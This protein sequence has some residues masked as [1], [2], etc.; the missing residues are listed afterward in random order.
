MTEIT[1]DTTNPTLEASDG[2][3]ELR[4]GTGATTIQAR[5]P[6]NLIQSDKANPGLRFNDDADTGIYSQANGE[7]G[8]T[9]DGENIL[10]CDGAATTSNVNYLKVQ[11]ADLGQAP[12]LT[13]DGI[14]ANA[15]LNL[16]GKGT[17]QVYVNGVVPADA[18]DVIIENGFVNTTDSTISF[19]DGTRTFTIAPAVT[20]FDF[21]AGGTKYTK[22]ASEDVVITDQ[23]GIHAIYYNGDTLTAEYAPTEADFDNLIIPV[24]AF[25]AAIYWDA[26]NNKSLIVA[27]E[28]HGRSMDSRTH[29][30]LHRTVGT[31]FEQGLALAD[32]AAD[33]TGANDTH[34]Q[35]GYASGVIW[36]EDIKISID[37]QA[38]GGTIPL[39]YRSGETDWR[40][41]DSTFTVLTTG[42]GRAAVNTNAGSPTFWAQTEVTNGN[43]VLTHYF[44]TGD[45][46]NPV[47]GV[48]GQNEYTTVANARAGAL[49]E[50]S[51]IAYGQLAA[52]TP[53]FKAIATVINQ[54]S[55]T[56][57][58]TPKTRVRTTDDGSD[59]LDW[60]EDTTLSSGGAAATN[61]NDLAGIQG[62]A[63]N[64]YQHLTTAQ[65]ALVTGALQDITS[66]PVGDLSDVTVTSLAAG[67]VLVS[68][69]SPAT[70]QNATLAEAG[71]A[72]ASHTH[73]AT[74]IDAGASTDGQV[75]TSDGAGNAAWEDAGGGGGFDWF[76][77]DG[78]SSTPE[79][80]PTSYAAGTGYQP[81]ALGSGCV[82]N[83]GSDNQGFVFGQNVNLT[84]FRA[85]AF[86][87]NLNV[88]GGQNLAYHMDRSSSSSMS[89][90]NNIVLSSAGW[91]V[92]T[93]TGTNN[94][95]IGGNVD[96]V[97]ASRDFNVIIGTDQPW[98]A[99]STVENCVGLGRMCSFHTWGEFDFPSTT[100]G[101]GE[102]K[103]K[104]YIQL[105]TFSTDATPKNITAGSNSGD[106]FHLQMTDGSVHLYEGRVL[107]RT[108]AGVYSI[109]DIK[110]AC[111]RQTGIASV[112]IVG[113]SSISVFA[114]DAS[115]SSWSV[116]VSANTSTG[117][118]EIEITGD[119]SGNR[120]EWTANLF[121][122][123]I[124]YD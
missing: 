1:R 60:R 53:E 49:S 65:V 87:A 16:T 73:T 111:K 67:E 68:S 77:G 72:A 28:R 42:T 104:S 44:A 14:D 114:Q 106:A 98:F 80:A 107:A 94:V 118:P 51:E 47:I 9:G 15:D 10:Y 112:A 99:S 64:D 43:F 32:I 8:I 54:T 102:A 37:A 82:A 78:G 5:D 119:S 24:Y 11:N 105:G 34:A 23:E 124:Q 27:E 109:W 2:D 92:S 62:G 31:A 56:Y 96:T 97:L 88:S 58:N 123:K 61:H 50:I 18:A 40:S 35:L 17:G 36:D 69:G 41:T 6:V 100:N 38:G 86:G 103:T 120:I 85:T 76:S 89:G 108:T 13:V 71:I 46:N 30:Y 95:I 79:T 59:Y 26:T 29:Q 83:I 115:A 81:W 45:I 113:T 4:S 90:S 121:V 55:N 12:T 84:S 110:F 93:L 3:L 33:Q 116:T 22:S 91:Q 117:R 63:A 75:L 66:E 7:I 52:L 101:P 48:I 57:S 74:D 19:V 70:W 39:F 20:S 122:D 21:W 25:I